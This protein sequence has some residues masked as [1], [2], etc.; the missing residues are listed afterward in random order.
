[1]Y[2]FGSMSS[3]LNCFG[4]S[5][6]GKSGTEAISNMSFLIDGEHIFAASGQVNVSKSPVRDDV[7]AVSIA[8]KYDDLQPSA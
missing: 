4:K 1:M 5:I 3:F 6:S 7:A 2:I 8:M